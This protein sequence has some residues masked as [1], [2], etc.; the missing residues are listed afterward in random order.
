VSANVR[1]PSGAGIYRRRILLV[2]EPGRV[3][4][5]LED[6][7]HHFR[8]QLDHDG[9]RVR[10]ARGQAVRFP[11]TSCPGA[12]EPLRRLEGL[13]VGAGASAAFGHTDPRAQCTHLFDLA[14]LAAA[15]AGRER[16][17][18][19]Y[20]VEVPDRVEGATR[21]RLRRDGAPALEWEL[22][23]H[24][25]MSPRSF[26]GV[27]LLGRGFLAWCDEHLDADGV[28]AALVL[29]RACYISMG[30]GHAF[31]A[32]A[33]PTAFMALTAGSCH[34]FT[35]GIVED[36]RRVRGSTRDFTD[37]PERLLG[38]AS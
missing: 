36:A 7:F 22:N 14:A 2:G 11:W 30:R 4:G 5:D 38:D 8:V 26:A 32:M 1:T 37:A 16:A 24:E 19:D 27:R 12:L 6:D 20:E 34:T 35:P 23:R 10:A 31:D 15:H 28:E 21:A 17:R 29:R 25:I 9:E 33:G 18:R 3:A 13:R